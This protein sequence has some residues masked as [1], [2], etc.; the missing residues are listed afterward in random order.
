[1]DALNTAGLRCDGQGMPIGPLTIKRVGR[2][3]SPLNEAA[4][5]TTE[6]CASGKCIPHGAMERL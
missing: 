2:G 5:A 1:M 4:R 3:R 6:A